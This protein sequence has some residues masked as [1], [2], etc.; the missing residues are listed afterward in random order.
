MRVAARNQFM[1]D[2]ARIVSRATAEPGE[3]YGEH[4]RI[5]HCAIESGGAFFDFTDDH[6]RPIKRTRKG[7]VRPS[8]AGQ[9]VMRCSSNDVLGSRWKTDRENVDVGEGARV[10][11]DR[12][13]DH[14]VLDNCEVAVQMEIGLHERDARIHGS[15]NSFDLRESVARATNVRRLDV[16][17]RR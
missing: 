11:I 15:L 1:S 10:T 3:R 13:L 5:A 9:M 8:S 12:S 6:V 7:R 17:A 2:I 14:R 16:I 4:N